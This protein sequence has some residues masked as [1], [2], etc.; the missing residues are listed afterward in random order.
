VV[1]VKPQDWLSNDV[2]SILAQPPL[3]P[4]TV[5]TMATSELTGDALDVFAGNQLPYTNYMSTAVNIKPQNWS[6]IEVNNFG[7]NNFDETT[8]LTRRDTKNNTSIFHR[9]REQE[10]LLQ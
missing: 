1:D 8:W 4:I 2:K 6:S 3:Y 5:G 9:E 10:Q 7:I